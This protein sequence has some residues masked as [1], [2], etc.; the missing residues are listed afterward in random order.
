[1]MNDMFLN[2]TIKYREYTR[3]TIMSPLTGFDGR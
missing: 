3:G 2:F 1:M